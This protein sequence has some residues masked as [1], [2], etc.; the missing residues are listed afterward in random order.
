MAKNNI[1]IEDQINKSIEHVD[2]YNKL[3][4]RSLMQPFK[5]ANSGSRAL[6][7]SIHVEHLLIPSNPEVPCYQTGYENQFGYNSSSWVEA[8]ANYEVVA[9]IEKFSFKPGFHYY[10]IVHN[11]DDDSY[12]MI[13]RVNYHH[14]TESYGFLWN[15]TVLD[16]LH[17]GGI[18]DKNDPIKMSAGFDE[19]GN[20]MNGVNLLTMYLS[21]AQNMEDSIIISDIAA[22][23]LQT[24][25]VHKSEIM[26]N[27]NDVL[28]NRYGDDTM[29]KTFPDIGEE[30]KDNIFCS[31][32]RIDNNTRL[33]SLSEERL[34]EEMISDRNILM[35]GEVA[36]IDVYCNDEEELSKSPYNQQLY[37]Y[38]NEK[39]RFAKE[40]NDIIAPIAISHKLS[41]E[42]NELYS[43]CRKIVSGEQFFNNNQFNN[44]LMRI[45][46]VQQL[47]MQ[48]GD[49]MAD[50][51]GGKGVVSEVRPYKLMP[52]LSNGKYVEVIKNQSTCI[53][54]EN[55]GQLHEQSLNFIGMRLLDAFKTKVFTP[56]ECCLMYYKFLSIIDKDLANSMTSGVDFY[57]EYQAAA[58]IDILIEDD[59]III[60]DRPFTTNINID[61]IAKIYDEFPWI[62]PYDVE[63]PMKDSNGNIRYINMRRPMVAAEIYNYRLKQYAEEKFSV[64]SLS[65]TNL[66]NLNTRSKANKMHEAKYTKTPIMFGAMESGDLA[67]M[68][69]QYVVMNLMLYSSSPQ[70]RRLFENLLIGDPYDIDI[71]LDK[72]S[73]NRNAEIINA[74][75]KTMGLRLVFQKVPKQQR[76]LAL[77]VMVSLAKNKGFK[78]KTNIRDIMDYHDDELRMKYI[79][80]LEDKSGPE[81]AKNVM[82]KI[83][84]DQEEIQEDETDEEPKKELKGE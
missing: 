43:K 19:F 56:T 77:N 41:S 38:Y 75:L 74:L 55:I 65:A 72:D 51:Y 78:Y 49:K 37:F 40:V 3:L 39:K 70:G 14:N 81:L 17:V 16:R 27:N 23:K 33:Y 20:K 25:L 76:Q 84:G 57:D 12:D 58:L 61:T 31:I 62:K 13:E 2:D 21:T 6:M 59:R 28:L 1:M 34:R 9:R 24:P 44:C 69:M 5:P 22:K 35:D 64:T 7:N 68:G 60:S 48:A 79:A 8:E 4:G 30:V 63:I 52:R 15:N 67:H 47:P 42:L 18:I 11:I 71:K 45:A 10:L 36:D 66:K 46:V 73:K 54:R 29:C 32:R 82:C 53:N 83:V 26:I 50:R 80:A